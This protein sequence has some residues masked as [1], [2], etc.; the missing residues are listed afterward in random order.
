MSRRLLALLTACCVALS[1]TAV[2]AFAHGNG[3]HHRGKTRHAKVHRTGQPANFLGAGLFGASVNSLA[4]RLSVD[5][6]DLRTAIKQTLADER[7]RQL[8]AAGLTPEEIAALQ[9]CRFS[10]VGARGGTKGRREAAKKHAR[11]AH[12]LRGANCDAATLKSAHDKLKAAPR[13]DYN[14]IK[15]DLATELAQKLG[16]TP[17]D[18]IAAV[19]AELDARL[20]QAV[21]AGWLTQKGHDLALACFDDPNSCDVRALKGEFRFPG[22]HGELAP[23]DTTPTGTA[24][25]TTSAPGT[26]QPGGQQTS[27][28]LR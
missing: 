12:H 8:T 15:T 20:T 19:R 28:P 9:S 13:P 23:S 27:T 5:P 4:Q 7:T 10:H 18:V 21:T 26:M 2:A 24:P 11:A 17:D 25:P 3:S 16:K 1:V 22:H 6:A 14:A